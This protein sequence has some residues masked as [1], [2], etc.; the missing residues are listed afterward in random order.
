LPTETKEMGPEDIAE[1]ADGSPDT[2]A[3]PQPAETDASTAAA[4]S[5]DAATEAA[6]EATDAATDGPGGGNGGKRRVSWSRVLVFGLLPVLALVLAGAA[7]FLK[8]Q[9][10]SMRAAD[11]ARLES[12]QAAKDST[13][14]LLSYQ[15]DTVEKDLNAARDRLTG[16]FRESYT[17]LIN[18][19]VI[20]GAKQKKISAVVSIPAVA[21]VSASPSHAVA[22][23]F[24][25]QTIIIGTDP[26][27][28][29]ASSVRVTMD[30]IGGRWLISDFTP[31]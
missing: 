30:K 16:T 26:P 25:N 7:G 17:S 11:S 20:P 22:L 2:D 10:A 12:M 23:V 28:A 1:A 6:D 19:V 3:T 24:V 27:S 29:T 31:V 15:P 13:I 4:A 14:A 21:S 9:D 18:D 5:T 8:W